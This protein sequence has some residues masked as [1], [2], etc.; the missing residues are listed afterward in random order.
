[1]CN[2]GI[3]SHLEDKKIGMALRDDKIDMIDRLYEKEGL[4]FILVCVFY[5]VSECRKYGSA[6]FLKR[7]CCDV[8]AWFFPVQRDS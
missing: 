1:M 3:K 8:F 4:L 5:F 2:R 6:F 7:R